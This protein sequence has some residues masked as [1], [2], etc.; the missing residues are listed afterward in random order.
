MSSHSTLVLRSSMVLPGSR[1]P[2]PTSGLPQARATSSARRSHP[3]RTSALPSG[4]P[5]L[6]DL[7]GPKPPIP[8]ID[9]H[10]VRLWRLV[11]QLLH[12]AWVFGRPRACWREDRLD[13]AADVGVVCAGRPDVLGMFALVQVDQGGATDV[14]HGLP[15]VHSCSWPAVIIAATAGSGSDAAGRSG[16][17]CG[18]APGVLRRGSSAGWGGRG[19]RWP[20]R[21]SASGRRPRSR[22]SR[23]RRAGS[24][25]RRGVA[26][27]GR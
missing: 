6:G 21:R 10:A 1:P 18:P 20:G 23:V 17:A 15:P 13:Q 3:R 5:D 16:A 7:V 11:Q 24:R 2:G 27:T 25:W 12:Q 26:A 9:S 14:G 22:S 8:I 4:R 19:C